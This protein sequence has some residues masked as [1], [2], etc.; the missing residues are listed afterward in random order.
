MFFPVFSPE[1]I[2]CFF[3][4]LQGSCKAGVLPSPSFLT[5]S[6][7]ELKRSVEFRSLTRFSGALLHVGRWQ[8]G[9]WLMGC[10]RDLD[11]DIVVRASSEETRCAVLP[12][13]RSS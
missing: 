13:A 9:Q 1:C 7:Y 10:I 12:L 8:A 11:V 5:E 2:L 4:F 6:Q 3:A